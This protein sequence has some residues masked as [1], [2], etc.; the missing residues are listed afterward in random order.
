[1]GKRR[2]EDDGIAY[3]EY[4]SSME[5]IAVEFGVSRSMASQMCSRAFD[6]FRKEL[7][8]RMI[9]KDDLF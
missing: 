4:H 9:E 1:M 5:E 7:I 2:D 6:K 3:N 8:K